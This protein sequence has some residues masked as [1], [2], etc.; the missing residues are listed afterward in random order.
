VLGSV[1]DSLNGWESCPWN[2]KT[3]AAASSEGRIWCLV[4]AREGIVPRMNTLPK[5]TS[6]RDSCGTLLKEW[7]P[8]PWDEKTCSAASASGSL[9][10][11]RYARGETRYGSSNQ[12]PCPWNEETCIQAIRNGQLRILQY[13]HENGCEWGVYTTY[14]AAG[15]GDLEC[16]KYAHQNGCDWN[17]STTMI[18]RVNGKK[19]CYDYAVENGCPPVR[20]YGEY[21]PYRVRFVVRGETISPMMFMREL[22]VATSV[23]MFESSC[24]SMISES[25]E[26]D[27]IDLTFKK[28]HLEILSL[29]KLDFS[30]IKE[31]TETILTGVGGREWVKKYRIEETVDLG[32]MPS[33]LVSDF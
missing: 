16:L 3:C 13:A 33:V 29:K 21:I 9:R 28:S 27:S 20:D 31:M 7:V 1:Q 11:L 26:P 5:D 25:F 8:C 32:N 12:E 14:E 18:A 4:Y 2:E 30:E 19:D 6:T 17:E 22:G 15:M 24:L 23:E 10:C